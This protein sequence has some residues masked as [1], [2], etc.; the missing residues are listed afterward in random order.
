MCETEV[1]LLLL[2]PPPPPPTLH[3]KSRESS[4]GG[5]LQEIR[6]EQRKT[7][8]IW[9]GPAEAGVHSDVSNRLSVRRGPMPRRPRRRPFSL[10]VS[11]HLF[12]H[13]AGAQ[14]VPRSQVAGWRRG[15]VGRM[16][17]S[18]QLHCNKQ[19]IDATPRA[20]A[21]HAAEGRL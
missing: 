19:Q 13:P 14:G 11:K 9:P 5:W 21:Q 10:P 12:F 17:L 8:S 7:C 2:L 3:H 20:K 6:C 16:K 18:V 1:F 15:Q 4:V